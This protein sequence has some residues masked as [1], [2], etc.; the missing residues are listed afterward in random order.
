MLAHCPLQFKIKP[1][2]D[3]LKSTSEALQVYLLTS[4]GYPSPEVAIQLRN[5]YMSEPFFSSPEQYAQA[6]KVYTETTSNGVVLTTNKAEAVLLQDA[7]KELGFTIQGTADTSII[8]VTGSRKIAGK[9]TFMFVVNQP[10]YTPSIA[11]K[12]APIAEVKEPS[13]PDYSVN[14]ELKNSDGSKRFA[15]SSREGKITINPVTNTQELFDYIEG[16]EG[17]ITSAQKKLVLDELT[18]QG[19][20]LERIKQIITSNKLADAFLVYHEQDHIDNKDIDVYWKQGRDLNTQDKVDI[21][22]RAT[23]AA[24]KKIETEKPAFNK[25]SSENKQAKTAVVKMLDKLAKKFNVPY[26]IITTAKAKKLYDNYG[27]EKAFYYKGKVYILEDGIT[28]ENALHEFSHPFIRAIAQK[29]TELFTNIIEEILSTPEGKAIYNQVKELYPEHVVDGELNYAGFEEVAVRALTAEAEKQ[30]TTPEFESAVQRLLKAIKNLLRGLFSTNAVDTI[31]SNTSLKELAGILLGDKAYSLD[32]QDGAFAANKVKYQIYNDMPFTEESLERISGGEKRITIRTRNH[33]TGIYVYNNQRYKIINLGSKNINDFKTPERVKRKFREDYV[34][35][36]FKHIDNF[37]A[38]QT[39]MFVYQIEKIDNSIVNEYVKQDDIDPDLDIDLETTNSESNTILTKIKDWLV[40]R[41][42]RVYK[43]KSDTGQLSKLNAISKIEELVKNATLAETVINIV[44]D[45]YTH[46]ADKDN[47]DSYFNRFSKLLTEAP[48]ANTREKAEELLAR[49]GAYM[50]YVKE[51]DIIDE[52]NNYVQEDEA[53][54]DSTLDKLHKIRD[55]K[56]SLQSKI[57]K[58]APYLLAAANKGSITPELRKNIEA[59]M[60]MIEKLQKDIDSTEDP[61]KKSALRTKKEELERKLGFPLLNNLVSIYK[62]AGN[63][64]NFFT[65]MITTIANTSDAAIGLFYQ[66]YKEAY[67]AVIKR[68]NELTIKT[69][70]EYKKFVEGKSTTNFETLYDSILE[71]V[72]VLNYNAESGQYETSKE[73]WFISE[74]DQNA[75]N[76]KKKTAYD[77]A[78]LE[79]KKAYA[80]SENGDMKGYKT[81]MAAARSIKAAFYKKYT[82][83]QDK[84]EGGRE[85]VLETLK[86]KRKLFDNTAQGEKEFYIYV[87][88]H[89]YSSSL[90]EEYTDRWEDADLM[91]QYGKALLDGYVRDSGV[92]AVGMFMVP[93]KEMFPSTKWNALSAQDKAMHTYLL[94]VYLKSQELLPTFERPGLRI[95]SEEK[96]LKDIL[97]EEKDIKKTAKEAWDRKFNAH[98]EDAAKGIVFKGKKKS[99]PIYYNQPMAAELVNLNVV[100]TVLRFAKMAEEFK[101]NSSMESL[102]LV[103][104][105]TLGKRTIEKKTSTGKKILSA[106]HKKVYGEDKVEETN[107]AE[108]EAYKMFDSWINSTIYNE[109]KFA[110]TVDF[111]GRTIRVDKVVDSMLQANALTVLGADGLKAIANRLNAATNIGIEAVG[112]K[113][114]SFK[115]LQQGKALVAQL[116]YATGAEENLLMDTLKGVKTSKFGQMLDI[117]Q[118][119][120]GENDA[121]DEIGGSLVKRNASTSLLMGG[122]SAGEFISQANM[123]AAIAKATIVKTKEGK[124]IT[125]LEAY[126]KQADGIVRLREDV[127]FTE[128]DEQQLRNRIN[129][130]NKELHGVYN[131]LDELEAKKT[132]IGRSL[133]QFRNF[134]VPNV[135]RRW[136]GLHVNYE[137]NDVV[138]GYYRTLFRKIQQER[139]VNIWKLYNDPDLTE[140]EKNNIRKA[141]TELSVYG[142]LLA[143]TMILAGMGDDDDELKDSYGY[144]LAMYELLRLKSEIAFYIPLLGTGDALRIIKSPSSINTLLMRSAKV[145]NQLFS[146]NPL[147]EYQRDSGPNKKGDSKLKAKMLILL[148]GYNGS[149]ID[150]S[151][152]LENF[153]ALTN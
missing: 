46:L 103:T 29:N 74:F 81:G 56:G 35:G 47:P 39:N 145:G 68:V 27:G 21:E 58:V 129:A 77:L 37:F 71:D 125:L 24:L 134:L 111:M 55:V 113:Y 48:E 115:S 6:L 15:S 91:A 132:F 50:S 32:L 12:T 136:Q 92:K 95:P 102:A 60:P 31:D 23:I 140:G 117:F 66:R 152:A 67:D 73:K 149:N 112:S 90:S 65:R 130:I 17:G 100:D 52:I 33:P 123:F 110:A 3:A 98:V 13:M 76:L 53:L 131:K 88:K 2:E 133:M 11:F 41:R 122:L 118:A 75:Y 101:L 44:E 72:T 4:F 45:T 85:E 146:L 28:L 126:E 116:M 79:E 30:Y 78:A 142:T 127:D 22:T 61:I 121:V 148:F 120:Q 124:E 7:Y 94:D 49:V 147:E 96:D 86:K 54:K 138:E 14:P 144:N 99:I 20:G 151:I 135:E 9:D 80:A 137:M 34:E 19:Y 62:T 26:E 51:L 82:I 93:N 84:L 97:I 141:L 40:D 59:Y 128:A 10:H 5:T 119:I 70:Q 57:D 107:F 108:T 150:P 18:K 25:N 83:S 139:S 64:K 89:L 36:K 106:L 43:S 109:R 38:G 69:S 87:T 104:K 16:K 63:D 114:F 8:K 153:K 105:E 143:I 1:I 42:E